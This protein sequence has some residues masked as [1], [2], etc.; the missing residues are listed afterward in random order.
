MDNRAYIDAVKAYADIVYR[1]ALSY[2]KA[3]HDAEDVTQTVF[4]KLLETKDGFVDEEHLRRWL[5]RVTVNECKNLWKSFW[6]RS[7]GLFD[8]MAEDEQKPYDFKGHTERGLRRGR[9]PEVPEFE[10]LS[11]SALYEAVMALPKDYR[12]VVHLFYYED[13]STGE[14]AKLLH[15][16]E[17]TVRT[18]LV[19]ARKKLKQRLEEAWQDEE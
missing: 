6:R 7:V 17:Q 4:M 13:Y 3:S 18:R 15:I 8:Q 14:I 16:R 5:I 9:P 11:Q 19:R 1:T 10:D 12:I 2:T